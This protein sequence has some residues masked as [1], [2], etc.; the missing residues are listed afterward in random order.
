MTVPHK[1]SIQ[2]NGMQ[3]WYNTKAWLDK[4]AKCI[5]GNIPEQ[6]AWNVSIGQVSNQNQKPNHIQAGANVASGQIF[7][8]N[9]YPTQT[10]AYVK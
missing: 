5:C 3:L 2:H 6:Q 10:E 1:G 4:Q 8:Q 9:K 7:K